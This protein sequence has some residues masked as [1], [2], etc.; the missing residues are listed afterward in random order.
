MKQKEVWK[1][2]KGFEDYEI[3]NLGRLKSCKR[4]KENLIKGTATNGYII[5]TLYANNGIIKRNFKIH[6]LVAMAF[7]EHT[8]N[9]LAF[10]VN[11]IDGDK[12]NNDA[13][14][15]EIVT[16]RENSSTCY[17]KN[18]GSFTSSFVGVSWRDDCKKWTSRVEVKGK[19]VYLGSFDN[20][21][22]ASNA[23]QEAL[24][25]IDNPKYFESIKQMFAP[26]NK[27]VYYNKARG[28]WRAD[29]RINKKQKFIGHFNTEIEAYEA[30]YRPTNKR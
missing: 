17:R 18:E 24:K 13:N 26:K 2:I 8:P 22:D 15:L 12:S 16:N 21:I 20:E 30:I 11:H 10:V 4:N 7:L 3:S 19:S 29:I 1:K 23:Y 5:V 27:Y 28:K 25:N 6:Q 14:N 9:G